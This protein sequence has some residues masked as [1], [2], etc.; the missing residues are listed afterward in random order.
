MRR[1]VGWIDGI[2][3]VQDQNSHETSEFALNCAL[4][5]FFAKWLLA[6]YP[7]VVCRNQIVSQYQLAYLAST[8][9][10]S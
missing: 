7:N 4:V 5:E 10:A 9:S 3:R 8:T 2:L 6:E 1:E